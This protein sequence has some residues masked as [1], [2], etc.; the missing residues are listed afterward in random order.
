MFDAYFI[1]TRMAAP[2]AKDERFKDA[3]RTMTNVGFRKETVVRVLKQLLT[4]Y[5]DSWEHIEADNYTA[6]AEALCDTDDSDP[7]V[8]PVLLF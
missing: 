4:L 1:A 8:C 7:K 5:D 2:N 6:L 3:V